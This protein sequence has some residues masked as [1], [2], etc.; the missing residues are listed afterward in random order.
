VV[1][2][3]QTH[4]WAK[5]VPG[6]LSEVVEEVAAN[7][8]GDEVV[9]VLGAGSIIEVSQGL[10]EKLASRHSAVVADAV[11][12]ENPFLATAHEYDEW[13][14]PWAD[15]FDEEMLLIHEYGDVP[16]EA[17]KEIRRLSREEKVPITR[18]LVERVLNSLGG[19]GNGGNAA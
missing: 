9:L 8:S 6:P 2:L 4:P 5:Y 16:K 19:E 15:A 12:E 1:Q 11:V 13:D 18:E 3:M 7:L 10:L 17:I 14:D